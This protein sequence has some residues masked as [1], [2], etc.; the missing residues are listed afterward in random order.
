MPVFFRLATS[1]AARSGHMAATSP[2]V[3][4]MLV[5]IMVV[6][7]IVLGKPLKH[8]AR[9]DGS[10][11]RAAGGHPGNNS[12]A[13]S[14]GQQPGV[15]CRNTQR[16][17]CGRSEKRAMFVVHLG[18]QRTGVDARDLVEDH[19]CIEIDAIAAG[20]IADRRGA[21]RRQWI[22]VPKIDLPA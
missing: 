3:V 6:V 2:M 15:S 5:V 7:I 12:P 16:M 8:G 9:P 10:R 4:A 20:M 11:L 13:G 22:A 1:V 19:E 21:A 17:R 18:A 14:K